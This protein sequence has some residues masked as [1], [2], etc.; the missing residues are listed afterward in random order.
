MHTQHTRA[1][2]Q[3]QREG[4]DSEVRAASTFPPFPVSKSRPGSR[5]PRSPVLSLPPPRFSRGNEQKAFD[6]CTVNNQPTNTNITPG[7]KGRCDP[8][9]QPVWGHRGPTKS[10]TRPPLQGLAREARKGEEQVEVMWKDGYILG[11]NSAEQLLN[12]SDEQE[13]SHAV[14]VQLKLEWLQQKLWEATQ[15]PNDTD[16]SNVDGLCPMNCRDDKLNCYLIDNNG[17]ILTSKISQQ[18]GK[19]LGEVDGSVTIQLVNMGMLK[20]VKMFDYQAMCKVPHH[21][22]SGS[23][24]LLSPVYTLLAAAKWLITDFLIFLLEFNI[25]SFWHVDNLADAKSVFH[26]AHRHK[27]HDALQPCDTEYPVFVYEPAIE[28]A[29]GLIDCGA[30]QKM[31]LVQQIM[32]S[33]LLL[34]VTDATCDCSIFPSFA[35]QAKEVKYIFSLAMVVLDC[36]SL[37]VY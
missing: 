28:E 25:F 29:N 2:K 10:H 11:V 9:C 18:I 26:H 20:E 7:E 31:F 23:R 13:A 24:P 32:K 1:H 27:K 30:C 15:Q 12:E 34:L 35:L 22:H 3:P 4:T 19:F 16:C 33:N 6:I 8:V 5:A 21:H 37:A 36:N 14:G 17:F